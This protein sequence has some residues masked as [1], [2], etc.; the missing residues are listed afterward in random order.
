[1]TNKISVIITAAGSSSRMKSNINKLFLKVDEN[2]TVIEKTL[3]AFIGFDNIVEIIL[4]TKKEF[5]DK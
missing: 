3:K 1:M 5:F 4:V 2:D